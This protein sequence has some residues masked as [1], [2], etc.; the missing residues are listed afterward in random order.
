M[1]I[2]PNSSWWTAHDS[3][4]FRPGRRPRGKPSPCPSSVKRRGL[5]SDPSPDG[6]QTG[7]LP[8]PPHLPYLLYNVGHLKPRSHQEFC[9]AEGNTGIALLYFNC[10]LLEVESCFLIE[11]AVYMCWFIGRLCSVD[12]VNSLIYSHRRVWLLCSGIFCLFVILMIR[13]NANIRIWNKYLPTALHP[14]AVSVPH[15][16]F[17]S[18][19]SYC[20]VPSFSWRAHCANWTAVTLF[21]LESKTAHILLKTSSFCFKIPVHVCIALGHCR[22]TMNIW[23]CIRHGPVEK[24]DNLE[25]TIMERMI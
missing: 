1:A 2:R 12:L 13:H 9:G 18:Y 22:W 24:R 17:G 7:R 8:P 6:R 14:C 20:R 4:C 23:E 5:W 25:L 11:P 10:L 16:S 21:W 15:Y 19:G 3:T